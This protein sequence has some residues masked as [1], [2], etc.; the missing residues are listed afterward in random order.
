VLRYKEFPALI[1]DHAG[2]H[3]NHDLPD[4]DVAWSLVAPDIK[5]SKGGGSI[6]TRQ[7]KK[8]Y[9]VHRPA[10]KCPEC[11]YVYEVQGREIDH[12]DGELVE[13]DRESQQKKDMRKSAKDIAN[14]I[15]YSDNP[16]LAK[17]DL[18]SLNYLITK[19]KKEG[20]KN[21][22][23][24]AAHMLAARLVKKQMKE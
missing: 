17:N 20:H 6:P 12:V 18:D 21:P 4:S 14:D 10:P 23:A 7:C 13:L 11:G 5:E 24:K 22:A 9:F 2:N 15:L 16:N 8:C 19:F 3:I 1:F